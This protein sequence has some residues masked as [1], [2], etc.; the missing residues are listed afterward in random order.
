MTPGE[1]REYVAGTF[2]AGTTTGD[3]VLEHLGDVDTDWQDL[4]FRTAISHDHNVSLSGN[5]RERMPYSGFRGLDKPAGYPAHIEIRQGHPRHKPLPEFLRQPSHR[6]PERKGRLHQPEI[7][8]RRG[9]GGTRPS[10]TRPRTHTSGMRTGPSTTPP[11]TD[12]GTT[13][14]DAAR[15]SP[16][17]HC[18]AWDLSPSST[19][20]TITE[21]RCE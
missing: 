14:R 20:W 21:A 9:C 19:T 3:Y 5:V 1:F 12:S 13:V 15:T 7:R 8:R 11:P 4:V 2:P 16:R 17:T 10:S 6:K 18:S